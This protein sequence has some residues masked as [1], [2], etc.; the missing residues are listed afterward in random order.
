[1]EEAIYIDALTKQFVAVTKAVC[2]ALTTHSMV[3]CQLHWRRG[4]KKSIV[5]YRN[6]IHWK[7]M[8]YTGQQQS[9]FQATRLFP[10]ILLQKASV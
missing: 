3:P 5:T 10:N 9:M 8:I 6:S 1:M 7:H 2:P 4:T